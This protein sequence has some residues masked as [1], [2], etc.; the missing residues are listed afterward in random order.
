MFLQHRWTARKICLAVYD[1]CA[2]VI[3]VFLAALLMNEGDRGASIQLFK[4][5]W[6]IF[7]LTAPLIFHPFGFYRQMWTYSSTL[8][9]F[10]LLAG[11]ALHS[12]LLAFGMQVFYHRFAFSI[13]ALY[14]FILSFALF[15]IRLGYRLYFN[16]VRRRHNKPLRK[17][18]GETDDK[19]ME[20]QHIRVLVVGAGSAGSMVVRELKNFQ[21]LRTPVG[22][23]DDNPLTHSLRNQGIPVL[24]ARSDIPRIV[25]A[26]DIDEIILA[27]PSAAPRDVRDIMSYCRK[28]S[29]HIRTVPFLPQ[30][31]SGKVSLSDVREVNIEDLLGRDPVNLDYGAMGKLIRGRRVL[32]TGAGGSIGSEIARQVSA[33][34]PSQLI[35]L[36]IYENNVYDLQQELIS[37]YKDELPLTVLIGSVRDAERID[38][39]FRDYRPQIVLHAAAHKHVPLMEFSK[40]DAVKNNIFG[41]YTVADTAGRYATEKMILISTDKAVHPT[42]VMG[43]TKRLAEITMLGMNR[44][45]PKTLYSMVRFGNVLGSNGSVIPLFK[46][47]IREDRR[48]T[49]THKDVERYFMTI[50]EAVSLVLQA[51]TLEKGG[52]IFV[53]DMGQPVKIDDLARE[54]IRL[55]GF[56]PDVD[57]PIT[58]TGLRP[59]EKMKEELYLEKEALD[60]TSY[61][62]IFILRQMNNR[63]ETLSETQDLLTLIASDN[64]RLPTFV[65]EMVNLIYE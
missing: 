13:Y 21:T 12:I 28:T 10:T 39:I 14:F 65:D 2:T 36:D 30:I 16:L 42:N 56:E 9:Y 7:P 60:T 62:K 15:T 54:L 50:P 64:P 61:K 8:D 55:S 11:A 41:T 4:E 27:I 59:G 24:G 43:A 40:E 6:Y 63:D 57:I 44:R 58:Y 32:I 38:Q 26:Y 46:R 53:L 29:A 31:L 17:Q 35:L 33:L 20:H 47:Q 25:K 19:E 23:V 37:K 49:V 34:Y 48:L 52:E 45:Y 5:V 18:W 1:T 51:A 3:A 22:F